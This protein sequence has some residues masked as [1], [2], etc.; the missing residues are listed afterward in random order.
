MH[1][2][3]GEPAVT[4]WELV[5]AA[6]LAQRIAATAEEK[7]SARHRMAATPPRARVVAIDGRSGAGKST[8]AE[9]LRA[10]VPDAAILRTDDLAWHE[11]FFAW[12]HLL[13]QVLNAVAAADGHEVSF[14]PPAWR[15]HGRVG[16]VRIPAGTRLVIVEGV[17]ASQRELADLVDA[18]VWVQSDSELAR[19]RGIARDVREGTNG[20][21]PAA[22][23][24]WHEWMSHENPWFAQQRPW[25]RADL[26]VA[27]TPVTAAQLPGAPPPLRFAISPGPLPE[28]P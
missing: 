13:A 22:T 4:H 8:L 14:E 26:I 25:E 23:A 19:E 17:G 11:P 15:R 28:Q 21:L 2:P 10:A 16:A 20:D 7:E 6:E 18:T 27:G 3:V 5:S 9:S 1:L 24:F 12:G